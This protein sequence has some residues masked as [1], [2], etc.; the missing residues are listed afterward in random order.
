LKAGLA[1][2]LYLTL[3]LLSSP[4]QAAPQRIVSLNLCTD[5]YLLLLAD[6]SQ[7]AALSKLATDPQQSYY[8]GHTTGLRTHQGEPDMIV[9]LQPD[10]ILSGR[11][12][13]RA[14]SQMLQ[15]LSYRVEAF[16]HPQSLTQVRQQL[17]RM[18]AL[19]AQTERAEQ[20]VARMNHH[21]AQLQQQVP[22][23]SPQTPALLQ[24]SAGGFTTGPHTLAGELIQ[25]AG[26]RNAAA[27]AGIRYYGRIDLEQLVTLAPDRLLTSPT[28]EGEW[29]A[30]QHLLQHPILRRQTRTPTT[31]LLP[32][33]LW[34]CGGP[35]LI[36]AIE[37]LKQARE[38]LEASTP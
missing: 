25:R 18:G 1:L 27:D 37:T 35:M 13:N 38:Q 8:A 12:S 33:P 22:D 14:T 21:L 23:I 29:S 16:E 36:K 20:V 7:I 31:L 34:N 30:A 2:W 5:Q 32:A 26:W 9:S 19:L 6:R 4:L 28:P 11:Y 10:L 15:Q 3:S 17:L 24:Y